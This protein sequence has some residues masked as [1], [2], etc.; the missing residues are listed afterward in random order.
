MAGLQVRAAGVRP[1]PAL[2]ALFASENST[3]NPNGGRGLRRKTGTTTAGGESGGGKAQKCPSAGPRGPPRAR[4]LRRGQPRVPL[5]GRLSLGAPTAEKGTELRQKVKS[6]T[7]VLP[8]GPTSSL[9]AEEGKQDPDEASVPAAEEGRPPA[10]RNRHRGR[11]PGA[12]GDAVPRGQEG[13]P[14][15]RRDGPGGRDAQ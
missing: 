12:Q 2:P 8:G 3:R 13:N 6:R 11:G 4:H 15:I 14:D 1:S 9:H 10:P 7:S 5:S